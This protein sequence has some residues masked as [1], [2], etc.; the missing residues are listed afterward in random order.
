MTFL[1]SD[2]IRVF[3]SSRLGECEAERTAARE[4][5]DSLGHQPVMFEAAGARPYAPRAVYLRG[6]E[7]SQIFVGIYRV[8]YGHIAGG[9]DISGLEDEYRHARSLGIPQLLY[10]LRGGVM[11][12][13]LRALVDQFTGPEITV[14]YY[15][16]ASE[17]AETIKTD[18]VAL[19]SDYFRRGRLY[20]EPAV[21]DPG[22][23]AEALTPTRQRLL[24]E[25]VEDELGSLL[26]ADLVALVTG[27][28]GS[29]KTIFL[30]VLSKKRNWAFVECGEKALQDVLTDAANAVRLLLSLPART[31][32]HPSAAEAALRDAWEASI[33]VTLVLDDMRD[34]EVLDSIRSVTPVSD[35]HRLIASSRE[36][37]V[38]AGTVYEMPPLTLDEIRT[39]ADLNRDQE[40]LAG[41]LVELQSA[42]KGNPLY[43][44][45]YLAGEPGTFANNLSEYETRVWRSLSVGSRELLSYLAWSN[46][47]LSLE[48]L[49]ELTT[50]SSAQLEELADKLAAAGSLL[51]QS[52]RGYSIFHPHAKETIRHL[53]SR[54]K[55]RLQYYVGRL[56]KWFY[57]KRDFVSAFSTLDASELEISD[58]L[59]EMAGRQAMVQGHFR[60]AI[61]ILEEQVRL[62][63]AS[64]NRTRE[65]DLVLVLAH[66]VSLS[67]NP[68]HALEMVDKAAAME[69]RDDPPI[70]ISEVRDSIAA[71]T[72]GERESFE[73]LKARKETYFQD[74][75][76]W[77][78]ARLSVELSV[79]HARQHEPEKSADEAEFAMNVFRD[80]SDD[81]G[82]RIA[83]GNYLS[84]IS[85]LPERRDD[86][87]DLVREFEADAEE[88]SQQRALLCN[89]LGRLARERGDTEV[90]KVHAREAIEIGR[91]IGDNS[92]V[93]NNLMN[94]GNSYRDEGEW[95][96]AIYQYEAADKLARESKLIVAEGA[97]QELLAS[98]FN[99]MGDGER[100]LHHANYSISVARGVSKRTEAYATEELAQAYELVD[101]MS[102]AR[103]AWLRY[104][105]CEIE[106]RGNVRA[107]SYG[108]VRAACIM[109]KD[110]DT[111]AY[112]AAYQRL[113]NLPPPE[114]KDLG[115]GEQ[116]I[117]DLPKILQHI[118]ISWTFEATVYH[119]RPMFVEVPLAIARK[120]LLG[121][122]ATVVW[123]SAAC[124]RN[125]QAFP[126]GTRSDD[127]TTS[128]CVTSVRYSGRWRAD[129]EVGSQ[130]F[131]SSTV[132]RSGTLEPRGIV[133]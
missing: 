120:D 9:M 44:R 3:V 97:A 66:T 77:N 106:R 60:T 57:D 61:K 111:S 103:E 62:S 133:W 58:N 125:D 118:S 33:A 32:L 83:R 108:F 35:T 13:K 114:E 131:V 47:S 51:M 1:P 86:I 52:E 89:V 6:L 88:D 95:S 85:A 26:D 94:L 21:V 64:A 16:E 49:G 101:R 17:L 42:S 59:L 30:S 107:G 43:L 19:L 5:V 76:L 132:G 39:F 63:R 29:G 70:A 48:D 82:Y 12:P 121:S 104:A 15:T 65:R 41:E 69:V 81:Y 2:R 36:D 24:R 27:P 100:A 54:S 102:D 46:R 84:A 93:C 8:G 117:E 37:I 28:L 90:A 119:C 129:C 74:A 53:T 116:L 11:E 75:D 18:L 91:E 98:M 68:E 45:Y 25:E 72:K 14:G 4:V 127:D 55:P 10:V 67:G 122:N 109:A 38:T 126:H 78:A 7:E 105:K 99:K 115:L 50:G 112:I 80:N 71:L 92:I 31:F 56:S 79:Y 20:A 73:R 130:Y 124:R 113:F 34:Q 23:L 96:S 128:R 40:L 22:A 87:D 123:H 110:R